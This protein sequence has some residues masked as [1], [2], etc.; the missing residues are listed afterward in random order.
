MRCETVEGATR[1]ISEMAVRRVP[2]IG[3]DGAFGLTLVAQNFR[4]TERSSREDLLAVI[5][6]AK[7]TIDAARPTAVNLTWAG[8][9]HACL[10]YPATER[11]LKRLTPAEGVAKLRHHRGRSGRV[12]FRVDTG[13]PYRDESATATNIARKD[14]DNMLPA[15]NTFHSTKIPETHSETC[16]LMDRGCHTQGKYKD[17]YNYLFNAG[18]LWP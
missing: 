4:S 7:T 6:G 3:A 16:Y 5:L 9:D 8:S 10:A 11:V 12:G 18:R 13:E 17:A 15:G 2:A 1:D 14:Y